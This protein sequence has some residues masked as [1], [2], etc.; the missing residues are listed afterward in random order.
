[1]HGRLKHEPAEMEAKAPHRLPSR[2]AHNL[3]VLFDHSLGVRAREEVQV[4]SSA[5][6]AVLDK[7]SIGG[8]RCGEENVRSSSAVETSIS[9]AG[10]DVTQTKLP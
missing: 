8:R 9:T 7:G 2:L 6:H 4:K 1:M 10:Q 5:E 3:A